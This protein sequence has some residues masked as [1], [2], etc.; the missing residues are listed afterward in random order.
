MKYFGK[1][2]VLLWLFTN[3][4]K[5]EP[6]I[7]KIKVSDTPNIVFLLADDMGYGE[8]GCYGQKTIK[9]PFLDSIASNGVKFDQFYTNAVCSP[10]RAAFMTGKHPGNTSIRGNSAIGENNL[11]YRAALKQNEKTIGEYLQENGY[12]TAIIG[13]WHLENP[14]SIN[15]WA[16]KRGFNYTFHR[17]WN[18][19][20]DNPNNPKTIWESGKPIN[21]DSVWVKDYISRDELRTDKAIEFIDNNKNSPFFLMMS[22][23][24]PHTP[25]N[26]INDDA[27]YANMGWPEVERQHAGRITILDKLIKRLFNHL[28]THNLLENTLIIFTS[29]NGPHNEGGHDY[30][31][32]NSNGQLKGYKRDFYEGGIRVPCI[33]YWKDKIV[34]KTSKHI[35]ALWDVFPTI[36][37]LVRQ[38]T[39]KD[40]NGISFLPELLG[41]PQRKHDYLYWELQLDGWWQELPDGGFRQ[42]ILKDDWKAIRYGIDNNIE[43]YNIK[44]DPDE[45]DDMAK[46]NLELVEE[47]HDLFINSSSV[48]SGFPYG[49]KKQ[50]YKAMD[51]FNFNQ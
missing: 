38:E 21:I 35:A 8:L 15:S 34:P 25:E 41:R 33:A 9:T 6:S 11:W 5:N 16:H 45:S 4:G 42:A 26:D 27:I 10:S 30:T 7:N 43:L 29:D 19:Y 39:P 13:K 23:K 44:E 1:I 50:N 24:I 2:L 12:K 48:T 18:K 40:I 37:D 47:M 20:K 17:Q 14:D 36:C 3:C 51:K 22:Y 46:Q 32:F 28:K 31:F 49:G